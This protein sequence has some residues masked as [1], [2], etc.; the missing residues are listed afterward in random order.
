MV[1]PLSTVKVVGELTDERMPGSA[2]PAR[3]SMLVSPAL[4]GAAPPNSACSACCAA[5]PS[6]GRG[7]PGFEILPGRF[8]VPGAANGQGA[9][10]A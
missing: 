10:K 9:L 3:L 8:F 1:V 4:R 6:A 2:A 5:V 7:A